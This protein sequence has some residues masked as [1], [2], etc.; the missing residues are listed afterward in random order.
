MQTNTHTYKINELKYFKEKELIV[1]KYI[2]RYH[3]IGGKEGNVAEDFISP[4]DHLH[5]ATTEWI[6]FCNLTLF[7]Q[8]P[9]LIPLFL[10]QMDY[11]ILSGWKILPFAVVLFCGFY[12]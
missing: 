6:C 3:V 9:L 12:N 2:E 7:L 4:A 10:C 8:L 1:H 11:V 5:S